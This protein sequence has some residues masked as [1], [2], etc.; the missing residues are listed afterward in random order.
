MGLFR[1]KKECH[2]GC[3]SYTAEAIAAA[4]SKKDASAPIQILGTGCTKCHQL[5]DNVVAAMRKLG[6]DIPME[7]VT[8]FAR[9]AAYGVMTTPALVINGKVVALGKVL[10]PEEIVPLLRELEHGDASNV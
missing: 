6:L 5:E 3:D 4:E 1:K 2:C 8:D 7:H 9:I 10:K